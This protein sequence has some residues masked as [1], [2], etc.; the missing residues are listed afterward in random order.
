MRRT[1]FALLFLSLALVSCG[2]S[3]ARFS[4]VFDTKEAMRVEELKNAT[5]R[6]ISR[7]LEAR[8]KKLEAS[9]F[10]TVNDVTTM[11]VKTSDSEGLQLLKDGLVQPFKIE[12]LKQV[13]AGQ[14]DIISEK[15]GEFKETGLKTEHFAWITAG[16]RTFGAQEQ[17]FVE[18]EFT[19]E[20][21]AILK[22]IF[23]ENQGEVIGVFVRGMLISKKLV[24][25]KDL[26]L[27]GITIDGI[28]R[29]ELA[30]AFADD[31]NVGLHVTFTAQ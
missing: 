17:G 11:D 14:G 31:A 2:G 4:L 10:Q 12:V 15:F 1:S 5:E 16:S 30:E 28:P 27:N 19:P 9:K 20:G 21:Q 3:T 8:D 13:E 23:T 29:A 24:E 18:I 22:K 26:Q 7:R 25:S 6:V